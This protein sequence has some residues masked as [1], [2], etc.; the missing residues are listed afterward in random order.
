MRNP[1]KAGDDNDQGLATGQEDQGR[2][3]LIDS[4]SHVFVVLNSKLMY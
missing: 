4:S 3:V 1:L 2:P